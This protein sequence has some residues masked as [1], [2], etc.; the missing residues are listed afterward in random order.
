MRFLMG[1][2]CA[3]GFLTAANV[4]RAVEPVP[5]PKGRVV[6]TVSGRV[7]QKNGGE[8][9]PFDDLRS[10]PLPAPKVDGKVLTIRDKGA[11]GIV[12]PGD[13]H[14]ALHEVRYDARSVWQL[15]RLHVE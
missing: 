5:L 6:P 13:A 1:I 8:S 9:A 11:L 7:E 14:G 10:E 12:C 3:A 2:P 15:N 4:S